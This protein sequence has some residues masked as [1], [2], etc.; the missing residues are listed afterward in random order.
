MVELEKA[1]IP[2]ATILS[3]GFQD[4]AMASAKAFGMAEIRFVVVPKV[5]ND[6]SVD[7]TVA[8]TDPAVG[9]VMEILTTSGN[10]HAIESAV[11]SRNGSS[12]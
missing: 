3:D 11:L 12:T 1:G 7:D 10:G 5:Y 4:D 2:T 9:A 8:Q 6:I